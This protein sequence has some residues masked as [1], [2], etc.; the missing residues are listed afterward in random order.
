MVREPH[1]SQKPEEPVASLDDEPAEPFDERV[2]RRPTRQPTLES[3]QG[4]RREL[5][6][7]RSRATDEAVRA[8]VTA[9]IEAIDKQIDVQGE[10]GQSSRRPRT[11]QG[12]RREGDLHPRQVPRLSSGRHERVLVCCRQGSE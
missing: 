12:L 7:R 6:D 8:H 9:E 1:A 5:E 10:A 11:P 3:L 2:A 4:K